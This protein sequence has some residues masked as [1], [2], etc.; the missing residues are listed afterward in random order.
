M[1]ATSS[2]DAHSG[3]SLISV[4]FDSK[5]LNIWN[6]ASDIIYVETHH[7]YSVISVYITS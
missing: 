5:R 3:G 2:A 6:A 1:G 7:D 4:E